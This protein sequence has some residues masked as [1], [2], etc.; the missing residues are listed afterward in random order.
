M[1][2]LYT[3]LSTCAF[4]TFVIPSSAQHQ[5][6]NLIGGNYVEAAPSVLS[7][8]DLTIEFWVYVDSTAID[9]SE[10]QFI[11]V[12]DKNG[13][14]FYIGYDSAGYIV[15]SDFWVINAGST[16]AKLPTNRWTNIALGVNSKL[17]DSLK[18]MLWQLS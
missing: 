17:G 5:A 11:S 9:G 15:A 18:M 13:N 4:L 12:G 2:K 8:T 7:T 3:V 16:H 14:G 1:R 10:H 6:L